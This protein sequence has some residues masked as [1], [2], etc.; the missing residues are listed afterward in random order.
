MKELRNFTPAPKKEEETKKDNISDSVSEKGLEDMIKD[1]EGRTEKELMDE[2]L[3]SV[4]KS[5]AEG[6]YS[7]KEMDNFKNTVTPLLNEEQRKKLDEILA[8]LK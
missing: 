3:R 6:R 5:K 7:D 8:L 2:L 1:R 4:Q